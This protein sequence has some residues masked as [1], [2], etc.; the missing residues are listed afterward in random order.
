ML[1]RV[2]RLKDSDNTLVAAATLILAGLVMIGI[3]PV[4]LLGS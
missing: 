3:P 2:K 1:E 4:L